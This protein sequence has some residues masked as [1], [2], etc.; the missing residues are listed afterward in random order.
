MPASDLI[1]SDL[2]SELQCHGVRWLD[3]NAGLSRKGGA[4]PSD[5]KAL[6]LGNHTAMVPM[7]NQASPPGLGMER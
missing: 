1:A 7:L 3:G 4:G 2:L 6:S 5:H